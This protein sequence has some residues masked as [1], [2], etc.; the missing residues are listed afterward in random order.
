MLLRA[1][2]GAEIGAGHVMRCLALAQAWQDAGG[3][4]AFISAGLSG[5][6][7]QRLAEARMTVLDLD[8]VP[9]SSQDAEATAQHALRAGAEWVVADGYG[10]GEEYQRVIKQ[11]GLKLLVLD[12][13]GHAEHYHA[14]IVLNQSLDAAGSLYGVCEP[15]TRLLLGTTYALLRRE[16]VRQG[17][18]PRAI[19]QI[20]RH[21]LVSF[22]GSDPH[23][24]SAKTIRAIRSIDEPALE[25]TVVA[26]DDRLQARLAPLAGDGPQRIKVLGHVS[27]MPELMG[28]ADLA[29]AAAG[30]SSWERALLRLPS[31][32]VIAAK[33]QRS[34]ARALDHAGAALVLGW[35]H[36]VSEADLAGSI[37]DSAMDAPLRGRQSEAAGRLVD[38]MGAGRVVQAMAG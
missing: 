33:N 22:G 36:E 25:T 31:L 19:P 1:D 3:A 7:S 27:E 10:F 12:D 11:A 20:A 2:G 34:I 38:G 21:V 8:Q 24:L 13:Y 32:V 16:F 26:G 29:I 18:R 17:N 6:L 15:T 28:R 35:W 4:V 5:E 14:D 9:G 30:G 23:D 37:R